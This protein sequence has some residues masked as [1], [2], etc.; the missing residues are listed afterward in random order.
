MAVSHIES[1]A[2]KERWWSW[3]S[4]LNDASVSLGGRAMAN[5]A[6]GLENRFSAAQ[7]RRLLCIERTRELFAGPNKVPDRC[8]V[9]EGAGSSRDRSL[10][11]FLV[12]PLIHEVPV[13]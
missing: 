3:K 11:W 9:V 7:V 12:G 2:K 5:F 4:V 6:K 1:L 13:P 10:D 8:C